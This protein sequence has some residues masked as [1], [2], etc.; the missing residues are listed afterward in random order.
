M[1]SCL[2]YNG[3][4]F[5]AEKGILYSQ[6][7]M[8]WRVCSKLRHVKLWLA[9]LLS[10]K[11]KALTIAICLVPHLGKSQRYFLNFVSW[12]ISIILHFKQLSFTLFCLFYTE[13]SK[14]CSRSRCAYKFSMIKKTNKYFQMSFEIKW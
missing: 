11:L 13:H 3:E 14:K 1:E 5:S 12:G 10:S 6:V 2:N 8:K 4:I 7:L 9:D